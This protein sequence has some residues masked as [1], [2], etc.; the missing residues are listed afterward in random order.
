MKHL[1]VFLIFVLVAS[2][3]IVTKSAHASVDFNCYCLNGSLVPTY[4]PLVTKLNTS[5][6]DSCNQACAN[7]KSKYFS[8]STVAHVGT[9]LVSKTPSVATATPS[10]EPT[11]IVGTNGQMTDNKIPGTRP[12]SGIITCGRPG[13]D[14]CTLCDLIRGMNIIIH[15]LMQIAIGVALLAMSIG[16][17]MYVVSA[18]DS[19]LID[20]AKGAMKN[21]AIGFVIIFAGFLIINTTIDYLGAK[22]DAQGNLTLGMSITSWGQFDC[23][24]GSR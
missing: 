1:K 8:F 15:Y 21:A 24:K 2:F 14:M 16:G 12:T 9:T 22:K 7:A 13:E 11:G 18:G 3:F 6:F 19:K 5:D 23:N 20:Q 4:Y 17:V 10:T